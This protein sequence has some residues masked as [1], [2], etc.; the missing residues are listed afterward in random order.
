M[1]DTPTRCS[2]RRWSEVAS[3]Q[4][5]DAGAL[6][7]S[8]PATAY[9][10]PSTPMEPSTKWENHLQSCEQQQLI[11]KAE[12]GRLRQTLAAVTSALD[13][14]PG[15]SGSGPMLGK[16][17]NLVSGAEFDRREQRV[18]VN[19]FSSIDTK[20]LETYKAKLDELVNELNPHYWLLRTAKKETDEAKQLIA[21]DRF[22]EV[23][24]LCAA[25]RDRRSK[26]IDALA[27]INVA[28][29]V[30][31]NKKVAEQDAQAAQRIAAEGAKEQ[32]VLKLEH[33]Q[34]LAK[35]QL[36]LKLEHA[37]KLQKKVSSFHPESIGLP[38][39][40]DRV[41][42]GV[43]NTESRSSASALADAECAHLR[44][45]RQGFQA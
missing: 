1:T 35:E 16:L 42:T 29:S 3:L 23:N 7:P 22:N 11:D 32:L 5:S 8:A 36:V 21:T 15:G 20:P 17:V 2:G 33:A 14:V 9:R 44:D 26:A 6:Q 27:M 13:E 30:A 12:V 45:L 18:I 39:E 38:A 28:V 34:K 41:G 24:A 25:I 31:I 43:S 37:Q 19:E 4:R 10:A 40:A